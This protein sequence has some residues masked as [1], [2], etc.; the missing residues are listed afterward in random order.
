MFFCTHIGKGIYAEYPVKYCKYKK[1]YIEPFV[2]T[3]DNGGT[4][5]KLDF[6]KMSDCKMWHEVGCNIHPSRVK[7]A[8]DDFCRKLEESLINGIDKERKNE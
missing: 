7:K 5:R 3:Q 8:K 1:I 6:S 2:P 4:W